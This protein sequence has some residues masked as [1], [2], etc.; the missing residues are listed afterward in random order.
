[1]SA[2]TVA[3]AEAFSRHDFGDAYRHMLDG[4]DWIVVGERHI[5]G[6]AN[7]VAVCEETSNSLSGVKTA[8]TKFRVIAGE[9]SVVID[10]LATYVD[11][12]GGHH[13]SRHA[14]S[15]ISTTML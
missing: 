7:V 14:I 6:K 4:I 5:R 12:E 9:G 3:I 8:F 15:T 2:T 13:K 1:M 11:T 10:R